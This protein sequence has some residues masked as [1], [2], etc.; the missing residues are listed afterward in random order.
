MS[1]STSFFIERAIDGDG[2]RARSDQAFPEKFI[3]QRRAERRDSVRDVL[4]ITT[5]DYLDSL[6]SDHWD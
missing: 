3:S 5:K 2:Y 4:I 6:D 1:E